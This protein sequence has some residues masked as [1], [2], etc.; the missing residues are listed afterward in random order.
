MSDLISFSKAPPL[1]GDIWQI[2]SDTHIRVDKALGLTELIYGLS[3]RQIRSAAEAQYRQN[4]VN[5]RP[6]DMASRVEDWLSVTA[7]REIQCV[8][9]LWEYDDVVPIIGQVPAQIFAEQ[10]LT[11]DVSALTREYT[12]RVEAGTARK[13]NKDTRISQLTDLGQYLL[14]VIQPLAEQGV[15]GPYNAYVGDLAR[16]MDMDESRYIL[17]DQDQELLRQMYA[18]PVEAQQDKNDIAA[19]QAE[20]QIEAQSQEQESVE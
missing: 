18:A 9:Y 2:V 13:P 4:N 11:Q 12:F 5:I 1:G 6:D 19:A 16:A 3:S 10:I 17:T 14:P 20:A 15:V 7:V 8:R